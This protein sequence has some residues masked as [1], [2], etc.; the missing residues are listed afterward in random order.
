MQTLPPSKRLIAP[1]VS[2]AGL[3]AMLA[4]DAIDV[5]PALAE[6]RYKTSY[7]ENPIRGTTPQQL[8][9]YMRSHP[10][11]DEDDGPALAN[12][13]HDHSV[14]VDTKRSNGLC[15]VS[16]IDFKWHFVI[17]LPRAVD[18]AGMSSAVRAM[19]SE[20]TSY[21]KRHEEQHR[22]I[23]VRCGE[24]FLRTAAKLTLRGPCFALKSKVKRFIDE[25]YKVCMAKQ[26]AFDRNERPSL[27][28]LRLSQ[29]SR[30]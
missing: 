14:A 10:I 1:T 22:T 23:F 9:Q 20:F 28:S 6:L 18:E 25:E 4:L 8:W 21:L 3:A 7:R 5:R 11:I 17:T 2:V 29:A 24:E 27:S 30:K 16:N 19:W 26:R 13:S 15:D 12:I